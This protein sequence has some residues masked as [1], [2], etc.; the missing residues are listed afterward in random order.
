M[1]ARQSPRRAYLRH[2]HADRHRHRAAPA[3]RRNGPRF[4]TGRFV[5]LGRMDRR[6]HRMRHRH[7]GHA[8]RQLVAALLRYHLPDAVE[9]QFLFYIVHLI[10]IKI[11]G[12]SLAEVVESPF[13][14]RNGDKSLNARFG[15]CHREALIVDEGTIAGVVASHA[16]L[17]TAIA[18]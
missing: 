4:V 16:I 7:V 5:L 13:V 6:R 18:T 17:T 10:K 15:F 9:T 11:K 14:E 12:P 8:G 3:V 1:G 2:H